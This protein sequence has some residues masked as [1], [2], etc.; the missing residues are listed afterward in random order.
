MGREERPD[1]GLVEELGRERL[2]EGLDLAGEIA[3]LD[4]QLLHAA[5][6]RAQGEQRAAQLWVLRRSGRVAAR[7]AS[8][9]ALVSGRNS[10]RTGSGGRGF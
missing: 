2:G 5:C 9:R 4:D 7:R 3:F 10:A 6:D 1:A 8:S